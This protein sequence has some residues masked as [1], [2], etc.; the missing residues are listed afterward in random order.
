MGNRTDSGVLC[1]AL[2]YIGN[3]TKVM[4]AEG[5]TYSLH[6]SYV[7]IANESIMVQLVCYHSVSCNM[8]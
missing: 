3:Q 2:S 7:E 4:E 8:C 6:V 5:W 1:R